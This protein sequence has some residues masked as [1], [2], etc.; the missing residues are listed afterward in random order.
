MAEAARHVT[1]LELFALGEHPGVTT[2]R[3][4]LSRAKGALALP[5]VR[6]RT[7]W[8]ELVITRAFDRYV[9]ARL[10]PVDVFQGQSSTCRRTLQA[11]RASGAR[12]VLDC[13]TTH[14]DS[15]VEHQRRESA[16][17]GVW[18][19]VHERARRDRLDEYAHADVVRVMSK[20]AYSTFVERG[21]PVERLVVLPP[22]V[23]VEAFRP[24]EF[25]EDR[26]RVCYVGRLLPWKGFQYLV[27]AYVRLALPDAELEL[28]GG[29]TSRPVARYLAEHARRT[30]SLTVR[31]EEVRV[32]G[33]S[34]AYGR[35]SVVV[36]PS[37]ADAFGYVVAEAM[38]CGVPVIVT[39]Q[40]GAAALVQD[41][42]NG[43]V[44]PAGDPDAIADRLKHLHAHPE[45]LP[46]MGA[47]ARRAVRALSGD[48]FRG[49]YLRDVLGLEASVG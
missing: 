26:F 7:D 2:H 29:P 49:R 1:E 5:F 32:V 10:P 46:K 38:A 35:A 20:H 25:A 37:L 40:T 4:P 18:P 31:P 24:T 21:F 39:D 14:V 13:V 44:I 8:Y 28:W 36:H 11:A 41:G 16:R 48:S 33:Y 43:Y 34:K 45:L 9:A 27:E 3:V 42:V 23:E 6:R 30:P 19:Y 47:A 12:S 15:V 17:F 22:V